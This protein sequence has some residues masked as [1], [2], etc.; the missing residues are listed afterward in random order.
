[1]TKSQHATT[2]YASSTGQSFTD[3]DFLDAHFEA[4]RKEYR[5]LLERAGIERGWAVLDAGCGGGNYLPWIAELVGNDGSVT[6]PDLAPENIE[7][8]RQRLTGWNLPCPVETISG[9]VLEL[10]F[11]DDVFDAV[12]CANTTQYLSASEIDTSLHEFRRVVRPGG[13]VAVKEIDVTL[14]RIQP[15]PIMLPWHYTKGRG[16]DGSHGAY[17]TWNLQGFLKRSGLSEVWQQTSLIEHRAPLSA[18]ARQ[19]WTDFL[20]V[21]GTAVVV[22][23][24]DLQLPDDEYAIWREIAANSIHWYRYG[25]RRS[26][27]DG[28]G[29]A[30]CCKPERVSVTSRGLR[31]GEPGAIDND[32]R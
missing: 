18:I 12:W 13:L 17:R 7:I 2:A 19:V 27:H 8:V 6:A 1:M 32:L 11:P 23:Q 30:D 25:E 28:R 4:N 10:P 9:S 3:A 24:D 16:Y 26:L 14:L 22:H 15:A 31:E 21:L 20:G 5:E 29:E